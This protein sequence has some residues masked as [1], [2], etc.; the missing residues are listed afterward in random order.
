MNQ[1]GQ[2][3]CNPKMAI[4]NRPDVSCWVDVTGKTEQIRVLPPCISS[5]NKC[6][7]TMPMNVSV[8]NDPVH[9]HHLSTVANQERPLLIKVMYPS[10]RTE[11][12]KERDDKHQ[13]PHAEI[14][15]FDPGMVPPLPMIVE[16]S[17]FHQLAKQGNLAP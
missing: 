8:N 11:N 10:D 9:L 15:T 1:H 3:R 16:N 4:C 14:D 13:F 2:A 5:S 6:D 12:R 7:K 17:R